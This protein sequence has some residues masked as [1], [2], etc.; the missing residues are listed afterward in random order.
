MDLISWFEVATSASPLSEP[1]QAARDR[2]G[3]CRPA[4]HARDGGG[5][6]VSL[7]SGTSQFVNIWPVLDLHWT[8]INGPPIHIGP[9]RT[10]P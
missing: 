7:R 3:R 8:K 9:I 5:R 2:I 1:S 6:T 4:D 10:R